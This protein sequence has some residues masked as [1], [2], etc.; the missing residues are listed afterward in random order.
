MANFKK[1]KVKNW[2]NKWEEYSGLFTQNPPLIGGNEQN[3]LGL[4]VEYGRNF[5]NLLGVGVEWDLVIEVLI[6]AKIMKIPLFGLN[7]V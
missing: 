6:I 7:W 2:L 3:L 5:Q 1:L 4:R